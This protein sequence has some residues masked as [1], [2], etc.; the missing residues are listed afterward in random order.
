[1]VHRI[2]RQVLAVL[3]NELILKVDADAKEQDIDRSL[4]ITQVLDRY[5]IDK[6]IKDHYDDLEKSRLEARIAN[7]K[8]RDE[9]DLMVAREK[10]E[11]RIRKEAE[12]KERGNRKTE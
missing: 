9:I 2:Y 11:E 3:P 7:Q 1:M 8:L 10:E 4:F 5:Y 6:E 12:E